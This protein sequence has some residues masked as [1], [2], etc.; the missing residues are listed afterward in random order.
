MRSSLWLLLPVLSAACD[1]NRVLVV[2]PSGAGSSTPKNASGGTYQANADAAVGKG[3][4]ETTIVAP[5]ADAGVETAET[6]IVTAAPTSCGDLAA[7]G[8]PDQLV[9][10][11]WQEQTGTCSSSACSTYVWIKNGCTLQVQRDDVM[12]TFAMAPADCAAARGW[13]TNALFVDVIRN[14]TGCA[15]GMTPESFELTLMQAE[16]GRKTWGC[17]AAVVVLERACLGALADR[18]YPPR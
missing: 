13:A 7:G 9:D 2:P 14:G 5:V 18:L 17:D 15:E 8:A 12:K 16:L 3:P 10:F 4:S 1:G 11:M 6:G